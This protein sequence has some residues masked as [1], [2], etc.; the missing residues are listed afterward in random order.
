MAGYVFRPTYTDKKTGEKRETETWWIGY[1]VKGRKIRESAKTKKKRDAEKLLHQR[2]AS[3][4]SGPLQRDLDKTTYA[5]LREL[6]VTDYEENGQSVYHLQSRLNHLDPAFE[7]L[8][9]PEIDEARIGRY[10]MKRRKEGA[11]PATINRELAALKRMFRLGYEVKLVSRV[12]VIKMRKE[13]NARKGFFEEADLRAITKHLPADLVPL[14]E[15]AYITGWRKEELLSRDWRHVD[16]NAGWIRLDPGETKNK[17][18]RQFPLTPRLRKVL[19]NQRARC[20]LLE[21]KHGCVIPYVF[22]RSSGKFEGQRIKNPD[23]AWQAARK[24]AEMDNV[25]FHDFRRTAV[26]NLVRAGVPEKV[27][28][29]MTGHK[30]REVFDRYHIVDED[31]IQEAGDKLEALYAKGVAG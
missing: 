18:G 17:E 1:S 23:K 28:M 13:N 31:W 7:S 11:A 14:A 12:P 25:I 8:T 16:F 5:D 10:V 21:K 27:A 24:R 9:A 30:T 6:L 19:D 2:L 4:G 26:R 20:W 22:F 3:S 15:V 29:E